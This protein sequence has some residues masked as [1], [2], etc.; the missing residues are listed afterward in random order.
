MLQLHGL[1]IICGWWP[2]HPAEPTSGVMVSNHFHQ[3]HRPSTEPWPLM[4]GSVHRPELAEQLASLRFH[5]D[6]LTQEMIA[7]FIPKVRE[8]DQ[9]KDKRLAGLMR[10]FCECASMHAAA[11]WLTPRDL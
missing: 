6:E 1:R 5:P 10:T 4:P 9:D 7:P 2:S 3:A 11:T 8:I